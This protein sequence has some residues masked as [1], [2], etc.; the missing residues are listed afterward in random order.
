MR[1]RPG[2]LRILSG[3]LL[4]DGALRSETGSRIEGIGRPRVEPSFVSQVI[5]RMLAVPDSSSVAAMRFFSELLD[6]RVGPSTGSNIHGALLL[7]A[8]MVAAG[9]PG[10]VVTLLCDPGERYGATYFDD[11]WLAT[12]D[13]HIAE[14]LT[15]LRQFWADGSWREAGETT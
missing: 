13:L 6:R 14:P 8:E 5:D 11:D 12:A 1:R 2:V 10:S 9:E 7:V 15:A 4:G 3:L